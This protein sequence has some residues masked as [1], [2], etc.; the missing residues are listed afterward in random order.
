MLIE[1]GEGLAGLER[2][3][4][5]PAASGHADQLAQRRRARRPAAVVASSPVVLLR[6]ISSHQYPLAPVRLG[7][8]LIQAQS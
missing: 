6:R 2:L 3:L 4:D 1:P 5:R 8:M 7:R